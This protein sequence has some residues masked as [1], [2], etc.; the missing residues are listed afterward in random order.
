VT[1][2]LGL[3]CAEGLVIASDSQATAQLPGGEAVR[4][5]TAKVKRLGKH[6]LWAGTGAEGCSQ[7]VEAAIEPHASKYG[8]NQEA[9]KTAQSIHAEANQVQRASLASFVQYA[10]NVRPEL[11]G[12]IFCGWAKDGP[13][14]MEIDLNGGWQFHNPF[15]ATG[16]GYAFAHLAI[17]SVR[18]YDPP[19]Q[20]LDAAKAIAY[21]AIETTCTVSA[22]G[23]GLPV[24]LG[25]VLE[26]GAKLLSEAELEE[27]QELVNLWKAKEVD[28]LGE[29]APRAAP[30]PTDGENVDALDAP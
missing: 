4:L 30:A 8:T 12:G 21:R 28:T 6:I 15:A 9:G 10:Q 16:S 18:H 3:R 29:V 13:W 19:S 26:S 17:G 20:S 2:I 1:V 5:D 7:R 24:Q 14:I 27:T 11:W 22:S 23:V 25:V